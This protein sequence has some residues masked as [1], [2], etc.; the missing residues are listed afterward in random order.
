MEF[1]ENHQEAI[2]IPLDGELDLHTFSPKEASSV[3]AEYLNACHE[4]GIYE[5]KIIHGKGKGVL[6][7]TVHAFLKKHPLVSD[8]SLDPGPSSWGATVV[9]L[10][11]KS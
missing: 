4:K 3:V 7:D 2:T 9:K 5:I 1:K 6:R 8:F 11:H 10:K